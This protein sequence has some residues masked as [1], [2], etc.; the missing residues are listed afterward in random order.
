MKNNIKFA[1]GFLS[2]VTIYVWLVS[3]GAIISY[4]GGYFDEL[5]I[6]I[7]DVNF[8]PGLADFMTQSFRVMLMIGFAVIG[9]LVLLA[10]VLAEQVL[11]RALMAVAVEHRYDGIE[12]YLKVGLGVVL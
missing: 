7:G 6:G 2:V 11:A 1:L 10:C 9:M 8:W 3:Y 12:E 5:N 4:Y